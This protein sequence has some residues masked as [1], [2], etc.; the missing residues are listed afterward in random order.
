MQ[1]PWGVGAILLLLAV[2]AAGMSLFALSER[3]RARTVLDLAGQLEAKGDHEAACFHYAVAAT[4]GADRTIC[5]SRIRVL[6]QAHGPFEFTASAAALE[7]E[8]CRDRS[9]GQG[10]HELVVGDIRRL[11]NASCPE[12]RT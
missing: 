1:I 2:A 12:T 6:W 3:R 11:V 8:Y 4:A 7:A 9:C 10:Y 5:E